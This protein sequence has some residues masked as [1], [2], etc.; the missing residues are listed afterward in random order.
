[1]DSRNDL[2]DF[3]FIADSEEEDR[4]NSSNFTSKQESTE[5]EKEKQIKQ[6]CELN[7]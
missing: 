4:K 7:K 5:K 6:V 2:S 1:M 3:E